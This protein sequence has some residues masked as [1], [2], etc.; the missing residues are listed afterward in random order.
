MNVTIKCKLNSRF[1]ETVYASM[2]EGDELLVS[3]TLTYCITVANERGY[4]IVNAQEVLVW[5]HK[6]S[7]FA[8]GN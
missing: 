1:P 8:G 3:A 6:N 5:L 4:T 2:Y 7:D